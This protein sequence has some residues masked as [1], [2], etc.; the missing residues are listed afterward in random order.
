MN[1]K[2]EKKTREKITYTFIFSTPKNKD[3]VR[4]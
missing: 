1:K 4:S 2:E 3:L